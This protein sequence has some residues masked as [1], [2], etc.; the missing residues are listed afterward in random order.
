MKFKKKGKAGKTE[1]GDLVVVNE[2]GKAAKVNEITI[3]IWNLCEG[4]TEGEVVEFFLERVKEDKKNA[5]N[6]IKEIIGE[7]V[8]FGMLVSVE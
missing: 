2:E 7:L 4:K 3:L 6:A 5:G 8:K 1:Q